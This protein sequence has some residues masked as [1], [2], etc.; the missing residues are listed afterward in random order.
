VAM[1]NRSVHDVPTVQPRS[2]RRTSW[3]DDGLA[4]RGVDSADIVDAYDRWWCGQYWWW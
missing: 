3:S 2:R 1:S 4:E